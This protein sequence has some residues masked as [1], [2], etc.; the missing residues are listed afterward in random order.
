MDAEDLILENLVL[1]FFAKIPPPL[2]ISFVPLWKRYFKPTN[3]IFFLNFRQKL[4]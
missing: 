2:D 1:S 4:S 3:P